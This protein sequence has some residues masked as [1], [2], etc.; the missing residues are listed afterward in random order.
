MSK[1]ELS[2][3]E[4]FFIENHYLNMTAEEIA[5]EMD[6]KGVGEK[7]VQA[8]IDE[9]PP[10]PSTDDNLKIRH[11]KLKNVKRDRTGQMFARDDT[12]RAVMMTPGASEMADANREKRMS[13]TNYIKGNKDKI[14][15]MD[16]NKKVQ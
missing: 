2:E 11:E 14:H 7:T 16:H 5:K 4:K 15:V 8:F 12:K 13:R 3:P 6:T 1:R 10:P 9:L